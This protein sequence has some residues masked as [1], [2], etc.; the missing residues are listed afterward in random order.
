MEQR[1]NNAAVKDAQIMLRKEDY[2]SGMEQWSSD[3]AVKDAQIL[4]WKEEYVLSMAPRLHTN[5]AAVKDVLNRSLK[6]ECAWSMEYSGNDAA[7]K[8]ALI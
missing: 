3:A 1:W 7:V 6:D 8:D 2:A 4:L 5:D